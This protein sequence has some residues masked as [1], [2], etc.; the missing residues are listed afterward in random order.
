MPSHITSEVERTKKRSYLT[1]NAYDKLMIELKMS[2]HTPKE[3]LVS[4]W[5]VILQEEDV[6][7]HVMTLILAGEGPRKMAFIKQ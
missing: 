7:C 1:L 3:I 4:N 5:H 2:L 6:S